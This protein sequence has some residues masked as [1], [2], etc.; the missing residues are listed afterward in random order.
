LISTEEENFSIKQAYISTVFE[1]FFFLISNG[2]QSVFYTVFPYLNQQAN[3]T[4]TNEI[5]DNI[6]FS[7]P[8]LNFFFPQ[9]LN[10]NNNEFTRLVF[11]VMPEQP[12]TTQFFLFDFF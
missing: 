10:N 3:P 2:F 7:V 5:W 1:D 9:K 4:L 12:K 11:Q 6:F 8:N